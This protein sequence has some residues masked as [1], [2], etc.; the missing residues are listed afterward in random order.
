M[1]HQNG[2]KPSFWERIKGAF[3]G[4]NPWD[5]QT[6]HHGAPPYVGGMP[7][8]HHHYDPMTQ[9]MHEMNRMNKFMNTMTMVNMGVSTLSLLAMP[10]MFFGGFGGMGMGFW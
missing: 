3:T 6:A 1:P 7:S 10:T 2:V 5:N 9:Q 4:D 8:S